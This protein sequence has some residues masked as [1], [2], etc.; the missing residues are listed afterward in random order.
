[1]SKKRLGFLEF[2]ANFFG[3][4]C[5]MAGGGGFDMGRIKSCLVNSN[6]WRPNGQLIDYRRIQNSTIKNFINC[7][8]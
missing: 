3:G 4:K 8:I 7:V 1:L 5:I 6:Y 2:L